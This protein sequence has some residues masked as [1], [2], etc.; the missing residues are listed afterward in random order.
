MSQ[1][2]LQ[3]IKHLGTQGIEQLTKFLNATAIDNEPPKAWRE[4]KIVPI[5]KHKGSAS[6]PNNYCSIAINPPFAK[7]FIAI[8]IFWST[9]NNFYKSLEFL[10]I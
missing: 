6:D 8:N 7:L 5:F 1:L 4:A 3:L 10:G 9:T 2:P